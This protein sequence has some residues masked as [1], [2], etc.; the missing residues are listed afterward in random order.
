[1]GRDR[2][3][4]HKLSRREGKDL[5]GTGGASLE[6]R[7]GKPPGMHSQQRR[8]QGVS[9]NSF[10]ETGQ[11]LYAAKEQFKRFMKIA[12]NPRTDRSGAAEALRRLDNVVYRLGHTR[13]P[14][15]RQFVTHGLITVDGQR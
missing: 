2:G 1:M 5:F 10:A 8:R 12:R 13:R 7:L 4:K 6:R 15:A 11:A 14:Q 9:R 3:P